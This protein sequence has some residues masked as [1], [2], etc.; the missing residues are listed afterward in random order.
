[1]KEQSKRS[2]H[3]RQQIVMTRLRR[4]EY[5]PLCRTSYRFP[6]KSLGAKESEYEMRERKKSEEMALPAALPT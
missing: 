1:M 5:L 6:K 3:F 2:S 4:E